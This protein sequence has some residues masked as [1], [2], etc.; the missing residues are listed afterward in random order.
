[1]HIDRA[2]SAWLICRLVDRDA[3]FVFVTD[4]GD[5]PEDATLFDMRGVLTRTPAPRFQGEDCTFETILRH[6]ELAGS[7]AVEDR[8]GR[9][10]ADLEDDRFDAPD[11]AGLDTVLRGCR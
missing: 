2:A 10:R 4:P 11:A 6:Y 9:P 7:G 8:G 5:V 3:E 1:M